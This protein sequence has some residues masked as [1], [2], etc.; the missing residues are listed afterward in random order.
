M[1]YLFSSEPYF[2]VYSNLYYFLALSEEMSA[3]DKWTGFVLTKEGDD[4]VQQNA[5]LFKYDLLY[6]PLRFES[7]QRMGNIYDEARV[8]LAYILIINHCKAKDNCFGSQFFLG[9]ISY[10]FGPT[11]TGGRLVAKRWQ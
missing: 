1:I 11:K 6:N 5:N 10:V 3:T 8:I 7:W 2:E 9:L 4:F